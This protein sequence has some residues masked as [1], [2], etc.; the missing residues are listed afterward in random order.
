MAETEL[1]EQLPA[2]G[3]DF[4]VHVFRSGHY[5]V[6]Q[7]QAMVERANPALLATWDDDDEGFP[8]QRLEAELDAAGLESAIVLPQETPGVGINAPS[9]HVLEY[10]RGS[11]RLIP[12]ASVNPLSEVDAVARLQ[13]LAEAGARGLKLYPSYQFFYPNDQRLYPLYDFAAQHRW[14]VM[15]HTGSSIFPGSRL[16][17]A[18]PVHIDDVAVDFPALRLVLAH[19]GRPAWTD[20]AVTLARIHA[21]VFLDLSGLPPHNLLRYIPDLKRLAQKCVFGSDWPSTPPIAQTVRGILALDLGQEAVGWL[22]HGAAA[23]LLDMEA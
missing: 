9:E 15:F 2:G 12:F 11:R 8:P 20:E 13:R 1:R 5:R 3:I 7:A 17:Y 10:C 22:F 19:A 4:H 14:P 23:R 16:K 21:N 6:S 18:L